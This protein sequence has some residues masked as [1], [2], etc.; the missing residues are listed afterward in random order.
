MNPILSPVQAAAAARTPSPFA[1]WPIRPSAK[2]YRPRHSPLE[3]A[4]QTLKITKQTQIKFDVKTYQ[5][6]RYEKICV[7]ENFKTNP[8]RPNLN[9]LVAA[10][11]RR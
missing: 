4:V 6:G 8:I 2:E 7:F 3:A 11:R 1:L 9:L 10:L 5:Y